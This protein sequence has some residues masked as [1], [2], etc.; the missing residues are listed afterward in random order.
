[1]AEQDT[2]QKDPVAEQREQETKRAQEIAKIQANAPQDTS[3]VSPAEY[4]GDPAK[5]EGIRAA[6]GTPPQVVEA[7]PG[8]E[9]D[10]D[11]DRAAVTRA[12]SGPIDEKDGDDLLRLAQA[13]A[14]NLTQE[15]VNQYGLVEEDL[16]DI[17]RGSVSPPPTV[18]PIH[19][20]ELTRTPGGWQLTPVGVPPEDAN[21]NAISR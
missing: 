5:V 11:M 17:A 10:K 4:A 18:G 16:R 21:K 8:V 15:F 13:K 1:M 20:V 9:L 3:K 19:N 2:K 14:P 12:G 7:A 6:T